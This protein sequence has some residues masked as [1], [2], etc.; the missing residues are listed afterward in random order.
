VQ[1]FL[2]DVS[3]YATEAADLAPNILPK[4]ETWRDMLKTP[5]SGKDTK[6]ISAPIFEGTLAWTRDV[7]RQARAR[8]HLEQAAE[9]MSADDKAQ[10]MMLR[11]RIDPG[12]A[13]MWR[14]LPQEQYQRTSPRRTRTGCCALAS[15][16]PTRS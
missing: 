3:L 12:R 5:L 4:L 15:C 9:R 2:N 14:G 16:G 7:R 11:Q 13:P 1:D 6:A 8:G 10:A